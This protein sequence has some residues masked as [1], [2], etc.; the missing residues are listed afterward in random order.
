MYIYVYIYIYTYSIYVRI[1]FN[2]LIHFLHTYYYLSINFLHRS[3]SLLTEQAAAMI[4]DPSLLFGG[5]FRAKTSSVLGFGIGSRA[6]A[7]HLKVATHD[8]HV[9]EVSRI[10]HEDGATL[11]LATDRGCRSQLRTLLSGAAAMLQNV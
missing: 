3:P 10:K 6:S 11:L 7:V 4:M 1:L 9:P 5:A 8:S 2:L